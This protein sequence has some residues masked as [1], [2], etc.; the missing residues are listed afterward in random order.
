MSQPKIRYRKKTSLIKTVASRYSKRNKKSL[1]WHEGD[2]H[3]EKIYIKRKKGHG[4][5]LVGVYEEIHI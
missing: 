5:N 2:I 3:I 1:L 4:E